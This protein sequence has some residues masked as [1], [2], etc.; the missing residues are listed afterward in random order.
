MKKYAPVEAGAKEKNSID[1]NTQDY[2]VEHLKLYPDPDAK[3]IAEKEENMITTIDGKKTLTSCT[4]P[5][6]PKHAKINRDAWV[7]RVCYECEQHAHNYAI[8]LP[9]K[10]WPDRDEMSTLWQAF[11]MSLHYKLPKHKYCFVME[12]QHDKPHLHGFIHANKNFNTELIKQAW[13]KMLSKY[14]GCGEEGIRCSVIGV[15]KPCAAAEYAFKTDD[16]KQIQLPPRGWLY[17]LTKAS[18][19][20]GPAQ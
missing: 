16:G 2:I 19:H 13:K 6:C 10:T 7:E 9:L 12:I 18:L 8:F 20:Y 4:S 14:T 11:K 17:R 1:T 3:C 5:I 15:Y